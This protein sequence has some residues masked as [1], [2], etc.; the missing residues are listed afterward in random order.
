MRPRTFC[1]A[2]LLTFSAALA[3]AEDPGRS[4]A[5]AFG[6]F[7][8]GRT[9]EAAR[10][11][12]ALARDTDSPDAWYALGTAE[13]AAARYGRA[14]W[15]LEQ[16]HAYRPEHPDTVRNLEVA[17]AMVLRTAA[18]FAGEQRT[19]LPGD[20]DMGTGL[21]TALPPDQVAGTFLIGWSGLF[22]LL[23]RLER[24]A[25][26]ARSTRMSL[27]VIGAGLVA[28]VFGGL[29][30][31]RILVLRAASYGVVVTSYADARD[32]PG[33]QYPTVA[34]LLGGVKLRVRG[35]DGDHTHVTLPDGNTGWLETRALARLR[36]R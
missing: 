1:A 12:E 22:L 15:A 5:E 32:G 11:F 4:Y 24:R 25:D 28:L 18:E 10:G 21:V 3:H 7:S 29:L 31:G 19:V 13:L 23:W 9:L 35:E 6:A 27:A 16:A 30:L 20:D 17:R 14:I 34:R 2:A 33:A 36:Y 26:E 8:S